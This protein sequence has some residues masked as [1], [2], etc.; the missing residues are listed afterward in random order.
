VIRGSQDNAVGPKIARKPGLR[1]LSVSGGDV[2][3][4]LTRFA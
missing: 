2:V 4:R 3:H 1:G